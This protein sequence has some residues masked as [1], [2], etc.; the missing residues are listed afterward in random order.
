MKYID[1]Q[2]ERGK[3]KFFS[4][5][6]LEVLS[7]ALYGESDSSLNGVFSAIE[8]ESDKTENEL[9]IDYIFS[10]YNW[11]MVLEGLNKEHDSDCIK[12]SNSCIRCFSESFFD[13]VK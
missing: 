6:M 5:M 12:R 9:L 11:D 13:E 1:I 8:K 3:L 7:D 4:D 10:E 2:I